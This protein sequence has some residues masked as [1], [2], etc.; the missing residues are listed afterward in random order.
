[1]LASTI[2]ASTRVQPAGTA[3]GTA[4]GAAAGTAL[5]AAAVIG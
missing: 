3:L 5:D 2:T 4:V 1:M